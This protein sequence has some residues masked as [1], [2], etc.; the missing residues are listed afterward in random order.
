M[1]DRARRFRTAALRYHRGKSG[2]GIRYPEEL[3]QEAV[4]YAKARRQRGDSL[5]AI[6]RDLGV[7]PVT[8]SRWLQR[9]HDP[10]FRRVELVTSG[11]PTLG[12]TAGTG[13]TVTT[14]SGIRIEGLDL[15]SLIALLR[16]LA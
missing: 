7:K 3:H 1:D 11:H 8:L 16:R 2:R 10:E 4:S 5:L 15:E 9:A 12:L 6:S 14:P 13:V